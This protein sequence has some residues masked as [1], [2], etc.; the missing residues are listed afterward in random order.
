M[1][2]V[3]GH[4]AE[5]ACPRALPAHAVDRPC[6]DQV[7]SSPPAAPPAHKRSQRV[8]FR[9][10]AL[11]SHSA[12]VVR[13]SPPSLRDD[14]PCG[15]I[16][17]SHQLV[18][19]KYSSTAASAYLF[20][21]GKEAEISHRLSSRRNLRARLDRFI[22]T[23]TMYRMDE[24]LPRHATPLYS[25]TAGTGSTRK[26]AENLNLLLVHPA[27]SRAGHDSIY[28]AQLARAY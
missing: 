4:R 5:T 11:R 27:L 22:S 28:L 12:N 17:D 2:S 19:P 24:I 16:S 20:L 21:P 10:K 26:R 23:Y 6:E 25:S 3:P 14:V 7:L 13:P 18:A 1:T 8:L 9:A 15:P